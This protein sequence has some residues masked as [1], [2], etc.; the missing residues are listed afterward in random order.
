[1]LKGFGAGFVWGIFT[2]CGAQVNDGGSAASPSVGGSASSA[3][4]N[5]SISIGGAASTGGSTGIDLS[6]FCNGLF[7]GQICA[8][9]QFANLTSCD[10]LLQEPPPIPNQ[11]NVVIDC[12]IIK[13]VAFDAGTTDGYYIDYG[14]SPAHVRLTGAVC[15]SMSMYGAQSVVV[16]ESCGCCVN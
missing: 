9:D 3:G 7:A 10:L 12:V 8:M 14:P 2:A 16:V 15:T 5:T 13:Q 1:M 11:V 4:G 6:T